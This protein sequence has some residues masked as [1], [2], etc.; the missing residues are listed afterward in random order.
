MSWRAFTFVG[1]DARRGRRQTGDARQAAGFLAGVKSLL[2]GFFHDNGSLHDFS[3]GGSCVVNYKSHLDAATETI[4]RGIQ[5]RQVAS[6]VRT[7]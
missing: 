1:N 7:V 6:T 2:F 4:A 5:S 3:H